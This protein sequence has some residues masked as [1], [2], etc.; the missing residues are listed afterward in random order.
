MMR[1]LIW[2]R[3]VAPRVAAIVGVAYLA[4]GCAGTTRRHTADAQAG[5]GGMGSAG[6]L[7]GRG[8]MGGASDVCTDPEVAVPKRL[9]RLTF[10]QIANAVQSLTDEA[11]AKKVR[12]DYELDTAQRTFPPLASPNEGSSLTDRSWETSDKIAQEVGSWVSAN[13]EALAGCG[14]QWSRRNAR[15]RS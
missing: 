6:D 2:C 14:E 15:A 9:V 11:T 5:G 1:R 7:A 3:L 12:A 4:G 13:A 10:N 8:G